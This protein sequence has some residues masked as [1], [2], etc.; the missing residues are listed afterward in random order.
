VS[1]EKSQI[2]SQ[3]ERQEEKQ[4]NM[5]VKYEVK[6]LKQIT[7]LPQVFMLKHYYG[8][9]TKI[10][11]IS[12]DFIDCK[13]YISR[14]KLTFNG[15][16]KYQNNQLAEVRGIYYTPIAPLF[17]LNFRG[18]ITRDIESI[19]TYIIATLE[20]YGLTK[21][22]LLIVYDNYG[23]YAYDRFV[24]GKLYQFNLLFNQ[25]H[26]EIYEVPSL[27]TTVNLNFEIKDSLYIYNH[28][29]QFSRP[30]LTLQLHSSPGVTYLI[31]PKDYINLISKSPDH[32]ENAIV[33]DSN[34]FY[35]ITHPLP[36][37]HKI[38]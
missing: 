23:F 3:E 5:Q 4:V 11:V 26:L 9:V 20:N 21:S 15:C 34:K 19:K 6:I 32:G 24:K 10:S 8:Q 35:L 1:E 31:Y 37:S 36:R 7:H 22:K 27:K 17:N 13:K 25:G 28:E 38:D 33:L 2:Q 16:F 12:E 30:T 18:K 29:I 14:S